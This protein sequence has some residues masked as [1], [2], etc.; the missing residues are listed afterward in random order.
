MRNLFNTRI[1]RLRIIAFLEGISLLVL[2]GI[3]VP[4]KYIS[5]NPGFVRTL[6]PIHG[7]L[8]L[9]F[10]FNA[11]GTGIEQRWS[12]R[13]TTWKVLLACMIPFGTF[14]VDWKI[15]RRLQR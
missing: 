3:A 14:Y 2:V 13:R 15:L 1:G 10:I 9:L 4:L 8:F 5:N 7:I 11:L 6:G 12:F